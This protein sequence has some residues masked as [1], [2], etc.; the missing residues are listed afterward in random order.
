MSS[1]A[2]MRF[3][4]L[5][6]YQEALLFPE[7]VFLDPALQRCEAELDHSG[8]P[9]VRSG[10]FALTYLLSD[11]HMRWA[12]RCFK[13]EIPEIE[14]RYA[15]IARF[16]ASGAAPFLLPAEYQPAGI[17]VGEGRFPIVKMPWCDGRP[18]NLHLDR[19]LDA[20][21]ARYLAQAFRELVGRLEAAGVRHGDLQH[22]NILV[23]GRDLRLIDYDGMIVPGLATNQA[24][25]IG[26][27]HYQH[28]GRSPAH[29]GP[30]IDRFSAIA[31]HLALEALHHRPALWREFENG[32]NLLF[33]SADFETPETS[34]LLARIETIPALAERV[35]IFRSLCRADLDRVPSLE[36][37]LE[38]RPA[39]AW[40]ELPAATRAAPAIPR[41]LRPYDVLS[42]A[43][44]AALLQRVGDRVE[45]VG[46]I[47]A[48]H[49]NLTRFGKPYVFLNFGDFRKGC[50]TLVIWSEALIDFEL[51]NRQ[52]EDL[53]GRW[54][55]VV[56]LIQEY[57]N[58]RFGTR[59]SQI[60]IESASQIRPLSGEE[61]ARELLSQGGEGGPGGGTRA[62]SNREVLERMGALPGSWPDSSASRT[63]SRNQAVVA[64][65]G[66]SGGRTSSP[67]PAGPA[68][69]APALSRGQGA[70]TR[71]DGCFIAT[72]AFGTPEE[73]EVV[74]LRHWRD[75]VLSRNPWGRVA[76]R[77]YG[78]VSPPIANLVRRNRLLG[79]LVRRI[80]VRVVRHLSSR[81][82]AP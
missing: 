58:R 71:A 48:S 43:D 40:H 65:M 47:V 4:G 72:A 27:V 46:K 55:S 35:R 73:A 30:E 78:A 26:H 80:L 17:L 1:R 12:V 2:S 8:Q 51:D 45:V 62:V 61:A 15:A 11:G 75:T 69:P 25:E 29:T 49:R 64:A 20:E 52:P 36:E 60:V 79:L 5:T 37:F 9:K 53:V 63:P 24:H 77:L 41:R 32:D 19:H 6:E 10:G 23:D 14:T 59:F 13:R 56:G 18:I 7:D 3:P 82:A 16:I 39:R 33:T 67:R 50:C 28:P 42:G 31:I 38:A 57:R 70:R 54:V 74:F 22:G 21:T 34:P 44:N 66:K 76:I 81:Q 68:A